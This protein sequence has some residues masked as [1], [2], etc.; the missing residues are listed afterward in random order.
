VHEHLAAVVGVCD[1]VYDFLYND[2]FLDL[3]ADWRARLATAQIF[4]RG[5]ETLGELLGIPFPERM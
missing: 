3:P 4:R 1:A 2:G 5:I